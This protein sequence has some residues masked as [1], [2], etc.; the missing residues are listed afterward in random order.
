MDH[1]PSKICH[2]PALSPGTYLW[3]FDLIDL[4][5]LNGEQCVFVS[6][7]LSTLRNIVR[8]ACSQ[9]IRQ[10]KTENIS[11]YAPFGVKAYV[12]L[13][14]LAFGR[15]VAEKVVSFITYQRCWQSCSPRSVCQVPHPLS[16]REV[17]GRYADRQNGQEFLSL[18]CK[19]CRAESKH[20][21]DNN[22]TVMTPHHAS[23]YSFEGEHT[24]FGLPITDP[25]R[26]LPPQVELFA[27]RNPNL[28]AELDTLPGHA[29]SLQVLHCRDKNAA[30]YYRSEE[31]DFHLRVS[32]PNLKRL[33]A[34]LHDFLPT[35]GEEVTPQLEEI[36]LDGTA[37]IHRDLCLPKLK[38]VTI[39][40]VYIDSD[41]I[42]NMLF[43][44]NQ[45]EELTFEA[46]R[47]SR[48]TNFHFAS[49]VLQDVC[50]VDVS[51]L[52]KI[53]LWAPCLR[54]ITVEKCGELHSIVCHDNHWLKSEL[55]SKLMEPPMDINLRLPSRQSV[56]VSLSG[57]LDVTVTHFVWHAGEWK[58]INTFL[59]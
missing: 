10:V 6:F 53:T 52:K 14:A 44:A 31:E 20:F 48:R 36:Y 54:A 15:E 43:A 22:K 4:P 34:H 59:C 23:E 29:V 3:L 27:Y 5:H 35:I 25:R 40:N 18:S 32:L 57:R 46:V 28:Q 9:E 13:L 26:C 21:L 55:P 41:A 56:R 19:V 38:S 49:N 7:D 1:L 30:A 24:I 58:D 2:S 8:R 33:R 51:Q 42:E 37:E 11:R 12:Q 50:I 47:T 17:L 39:R 16:H 45:L